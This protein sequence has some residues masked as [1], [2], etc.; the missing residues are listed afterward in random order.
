M[1]ND[2]IPNPGS[3]EAIE[4]GCLCPV[5]DNAH[6][7]GYMG[8]AKSSSGEP[9]FVMNME[10]PLHGVPIKLPQSND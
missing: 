2:S 5:L 6:G 1:S 10:C 7:L 3:G 8:G 4:Q 9:L